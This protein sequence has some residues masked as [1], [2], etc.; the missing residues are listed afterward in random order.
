MYPS[1]TWRQIQR[2]CCWITPPS[3]CKLWFSLRWLLV[4]THVMRRPCWCTKQW[5]NVAHVLRNSNIKFPK[6]FFHDCSEHQHG[7]RDVAWRLR[8]EADAVEM[9]CIWEDSL[10]QPQCFA[11]VT[12]RIIYSSFVSILDRNCLKNWTLSFSFLLAGSSQSSLKMRI[13]L[14][15]Q[16]VEKAMIELS[17]GVSIFT[18]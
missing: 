13:K 9:V 16:S 8:I 10:H 15:K 6:D 3:W 4:F 17:A 14:G 5:Q 11:T 18:L 12:I 1:S 7:R 2:P